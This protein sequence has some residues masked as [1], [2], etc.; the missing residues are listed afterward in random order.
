MDT[1]TPIGL[2]DDA[3]S[4]RPVAIPLYLRLRH[5]HVIGAVGTGK[6]TLMEQMALH[7]ILGGYG[8]AVLDPHGS[9]V[10]EQA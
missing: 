4:R 5:T 7:D 8:V 2:L 3:N 6:S 10:P 9:L 1:A